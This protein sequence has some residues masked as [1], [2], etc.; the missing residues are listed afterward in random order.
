MARGRPEFSWPA[1]CSH[2]RD[3]TRMDP[4]SGPCQRRKT[5]LRIMRMT[6]MALIALCGLGRAAVAQEQPQGQFQGKVNVTEVLL[7]VLVTDARGNVIVGLDKNE[8]VVKEN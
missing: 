1:P 7:D 6:A 8:F 4:Q 2:S 3:R 5:M